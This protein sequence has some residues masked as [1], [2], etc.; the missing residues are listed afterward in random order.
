VTGT[1]EELQQIQQML[2]SLQQRVS[3]LTQPEPAVG[4]AGGLE[5]GSAS[6]EVT[7]TGLPESALSPNSAPG[8][9][10]TLSA[11]SVSP[12]THPTATDSDLLS[13]LR[14]GIAELDAAADFKDIPRFFG[15]QA[16]KLGLRFLLLKRWRTGLQVLKAV[17]ATMP[18]EACQKRRDGRAPIPIPEDEF[19]TAISEERSI[20][21]GP[22]PVK[23]FPLEL[24][25]LLGR[26]SKDRQIVVLPMVVRGNWNTFVYLDA[27]H[28]TE[29][30]L[31]ALEIL[32]RYALTKL[33]RLGSVQ[34]R[35]GKRVAA[36]ARQELT[37]RQEQ[38]ARRLEASSLATNMPSL[39]EASAGDD[40]VSQA[41]Q[42]FA[43]MQSA[44][45]A[46]TAGDPSAHAPG[47]TQPVAESGAETLST[48]PD[49]GSELTPEQLLR[50]S[51]ELPALPRA[52]CHILAVIEDPR[53]TATRLEKAIATDQALTAK[54]LRVAN[55]PFYGAV[56]DIKTVSEAIVRLGFVSIRNWT[57]VAA[58]KS[59]FLAPGTGLLFK[60]IWRQSVLSAL[61][62][63][64]V[65]QAVK[66]P[67]S[68][69][70][71]IGGL[72]Q[73]IGQLVLAR[74]EPELFQSVIES[75]SSS[76]RPYHLVERD[77]LGFDHGELGAQLIREWNLSQQLE[78]AV[79]GHHRLDEDIPEIKMAA[80]I[81]LGE[82]IAAVTSGA[83]LMTDGD[84]DDSE[85]AAIL[86]VSET[87]YHDLREQA[88]HVNIDPM[89]FS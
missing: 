55:S 65:A 37:R 67:E 6:G 64:L 50:H 80:M 85:A 72:M 66:Y 24:T 89:F 40:P 43:A 70:V 57:M 29:R 42:I 3:D 7:A 18:E 26:G 79:R 28:G 60:K 11:E 33:D 8:S 4:S 69:A 82:E 32:A 54:V 86:D 14:A 12:D 83:D 62:A 81:A 74:A 59:V 25:L 48:P 68:E 17:G 88:D 16:V 9:E 56:R 27:D 21:A 44:P 41:D 22:V 52:A 39:N 2:E 36:I 5:A 84:W 58:T 73:N 30:A 53:T 10:G 1:A 35:G 38:Q 71:F 31:G 23:H 49:N 47:V 34:P 76:R 46:H 87:L 20:Y 13:L 15:R 19:F 78:E 77:I 51:G 75:S 61:S 63:Q 45:Q